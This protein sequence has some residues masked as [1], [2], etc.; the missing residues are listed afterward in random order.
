[1]ADLSKNTILYGFAQ[2]LERV[3]SF[4][5]LPLLTK[6]ISLSD[7]SIWSQSIV[8]AGI[9]TPIFLLGFQTAL[10]KFLP[11]WKSIKLEFALLKFILLIVFVFMSLM[12]VSFYLA[13]A[14]LAFLF[15]GPDTKQ[16]FVSILVFLIISEVL[17]EFILAVLRSKNLIK[18]ISFYILIK[19]LWRVAGISIAIYGFDKSFFDAFKI[20]VFSQGAIIL[21]IFFFEMPMR[22]ILMAKFSDI[23]P[24]IKEV[25]IFSFPLL[26]L[27]LIL[28]LNNFSDRF[29]ILHVLGDKE[30]SLYVAAY[31]LVAICSFFYSVVGFTIFPVLSQHWA[32]KAHKNVVS[33]FKKVFIVYFYFLL[34]FL[35]LLISV[36]PDLLM[37]LTLKDYEVSRFTLFAMGLSAGAFGLYQITY[38][39]HLLH[40]GSLY[41]LKIILGSSLVNVFLN[42]VFIP[43]FG[44]FGGALA[45]LISN[46]LLAFFG[47]RNFFKAVLL[48]FPSIIIFKMSIRAFM[49]GFLIW[50]E[51][52]WIGDSNLII[53]GCEIFS[54]ALL[55]LML[56]EFDKQCSI[57]RLVKLI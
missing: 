56:N 50:L 41:G 46:A 25:I 16:V 57:L 35:A 17:F 24:H 4:F 48:K 21:F 6:A 31:S 9:A 29:I 36:G 32:N 44:I 38:Y 10:I 1:L 11:K 34:P 20:F 51:I 54:G 40:R 30:L 19:G 15:F 5:L 22:K 23:R 27:G 2:L 3:G 37:A 43:I 7:Y 28:P 55:Y 53:L 13:R 18:K 33:L 52:L 14:D 45:G 39:A 47:F 49:M 26:L 12:A 8:I 42:L